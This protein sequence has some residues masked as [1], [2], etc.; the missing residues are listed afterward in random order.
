M[1]RQMEGKII[2]LYKK[3]LHIVMLNIGQ[4]EKTFLFASLNKKR[5]KNNVY[6]ES[7]T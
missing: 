7:G 1:D 4:E 3:N 5:E 2:S 6:R